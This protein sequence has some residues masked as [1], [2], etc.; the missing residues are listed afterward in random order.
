MQEQLSPISS[1]VKIL[2]TLE[3]DYHGATTTNEDH[4]L[5]LEGLKEVSRPGGF[6]AVG[7]YQNLDIA[8]ELEADVIVLGDLDKRAVEKNRAVLQIIESTPNVEDIL[9]KLLQLIE[10]LGGP[11]E[12]REFKNRII[13]QGSNTG[14]RIKLEWAHSQKALDRLRE[15]IK[16][17][18]IAVAQVDITDPD[19]MAV[20][21]EFFAKHDTEMNTAYLSNTIS[22]KQFNPKIKTQHATTSKALYTAGGNDKTLLIRSAPGTDLKVLKKIFEDMVSIVPISKMKELITE[23]LDDKEQHYGPNTLKLRETIE[24]VFSGNRMQ[25]DFEFFTQSLQEYQDHINNNQ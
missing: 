14:S 23:N 18:R 4:L 9:P 21:G 24:R 5:L 16:Q 11:D 15:L 6:F 2:Q 1:N 7:E 3:N 13:P 25:Y 22:Y 20:V 19:S 17:G 10:D 12:I 8:L